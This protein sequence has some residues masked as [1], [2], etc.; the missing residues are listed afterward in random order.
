MH[1][2]QWLNFCINTYFLDRRRFERLELQPVIAKDFVP[3]LRRWMNGVKEDY[4][5][6]L[7]QE[8]SLLKIMSPNL[9]ARVTEIINMTSNHDQLPQDAPNTQENAPSMN[10]GANVANDSSIDGGN[11]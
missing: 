9:F 5:R 2:T 11:H 6:R 8:L 4:I 3:P 10:S 1:P 7:Q